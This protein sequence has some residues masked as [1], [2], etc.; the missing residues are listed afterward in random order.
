MKKVFFLFG[1]LVFISCQPLCAESPRPVVFVSIPPQAWLVRAVSGDR[2]D[3]RVLLPRGAD[4]HTYEPTLR[5]M[6]ELSGAALYLTQGMPFE[7][8]ILPRISALNAGLTIA[9][10]D[11]GIV[12]QAGSHG[13]SPSHGDP[14]V[15]LAPPCFARMATNTVRA[16]VRAFPEQQALWRGA[17]DHAVSPIHEADAAFRQ[18]SAA[19]KNRTWAVYHPAWHYLADAYGWTILVIEQDGKP[20]SARHLAAVMKA[21]RRAGV[22]TVIVNPQN[23]PRPARLVAGQIGA[24]VVEVDP[25]QEDW[26]ALMRRMANLMGPPSPAA[27]SAPGRESMGNEAATYGGKVAP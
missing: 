25:L 21:A 18:R 5:Q 1:F 19:A 22:R 4:P 26:P 11:E 12:K 20:P 24:R 16:L 13:D 10:M 23:D 27:E 6:R 8:K 14:H 15:W 9:P 2:L 17:L 7:E 3:V